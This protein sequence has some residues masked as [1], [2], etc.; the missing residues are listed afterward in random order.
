M[1]KTHGSVRNGVMMMTEM[2]TPKQ[3]KPSGQRQRFTLT[4]IAALMEGLGS[5]QDDLKFI[6]LAGT[7]GKGSVAAMLASILTRAGYKTGLF[8]SPYINFFNERIQ[9]GGVP[10][11]DNDLGEL[12]TRV[13]KIANG[14]GERPSEFEFVTAVALAYFAAAKCDIVVLEAGLGGRLDATNIIKVPE[15]AV[16]TPISWD[17]TAE[18]GES[19][20]AIAGE[21]AG[22]IKEKGFVV[23]APQAEEAAAVLQ[24]ASVQ[25]KGTLKGVSYESLKERT[26]SL[27]GQR[28][29]FGECRDL[30][31]CLLGD[32][33]QQ[34]A[35]TALTVVDVLK[36][37][38]WHI[39]ETAVHTGLRETKWPAR[40]ELLS[41][42]PPF[43][44]DGGHNAQSWSCS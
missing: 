38:G 9:I 8:T 20:A 17:H 22:I 34:N 30:E 24:A 40:F 28:F 33:Q 7:N 12:T 5:P 19:L 1:G 42:K 15:V 21:K 35:A 3:K 6:H 18:L 44:V 27:T 36:D 4:R 25:K 29:D 16:I 41:P 14:I 13:E 31:L 11:N 26:N 43:I 2:K 37:Q 39:S 23:T 10:I 32:Y